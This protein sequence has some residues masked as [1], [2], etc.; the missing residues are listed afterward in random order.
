MQD[1][2][3]QPPPQQQRDKTRRD[4]EA[5]DKAQDWRTHVEHAVGL[6]ENEELHVRQVNV[7][8]V[9][10]VKQPPRARHKNVQP[11]PKEE[12]SDERAILRRRQ[13]KR[14][15]SNR[16]SNAHQTTVAHLAQRPRLGVLLHAAK[17]DSGAEVEV[18]CVGGC[19]L[20]D[21]A[22]KF[23]RWRQHQ[24]ANLR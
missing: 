16:T 14:K 12:E 19:P 4:R 3:R 8:L 21:L 15:A 9:V 23:A 11:L 1:H 13:Q 10:K 7:S 17:D 22:R 20:V 5:Q 6:V 24:R 2:K 18:A